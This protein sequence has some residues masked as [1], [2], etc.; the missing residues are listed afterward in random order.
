MLAVLR[1][2][3]KGQEVASLY[4]QL[5]PLVSDANHL[6]VAVCLADNALGSWAEAWRCK[7]PE[8]RLGMTLTGMMSQLLG[9]WL[10]GEK[11]V[12]PESFKTKKARR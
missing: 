8:V 5:R 12:D 2:S 10:P 4:E 1:L 11:M 3:E 6:A 9:D 7:L